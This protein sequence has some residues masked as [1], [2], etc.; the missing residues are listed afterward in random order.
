ME[1]G[2]E[3]ERPCSGG[4]RDPLSWSWKRNVPKII[5]SSAG[6]PETMRRSV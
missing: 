1:G 4:R 6:V 2:E 3:E 5:Q